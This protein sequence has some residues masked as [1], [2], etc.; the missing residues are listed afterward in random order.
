MKQPEALK[1]K[2]TAPGE[3]SPGAVR[4]GPWR[5]AGYQKSSVAVTNTRR[6]SP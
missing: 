4:V 6:G 1:G 5:G 2:E 3:V